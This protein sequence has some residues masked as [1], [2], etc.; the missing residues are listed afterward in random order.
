MN[1]EYVTKPSFDFDGRPY[2]STQKTI[3][4]IVFWVRWVAEGEKRKSEGEFVALANRV[5]STLERVAGVKSNKENNIT[6]IS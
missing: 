5:F 2:W 4:G 3:S 1:I 6:Y